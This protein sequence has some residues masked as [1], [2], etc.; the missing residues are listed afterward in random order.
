MCQIL[1]PNSQSPSHTDYASLYISLCVHIASPQSLSSPNP[2]TI[3]SFR[4]VTICHFILHL[5]QVYLDYASNTTTA[6]TSSAIQFASQVVGNLGAP[7]DVEDEDEH[8]L[9]RHRT[10]SHI[11]PRRW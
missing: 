2:S 9:E 7:L 6:P 11:D 5:R 3:T 8:A 1:I 10:A 4:S